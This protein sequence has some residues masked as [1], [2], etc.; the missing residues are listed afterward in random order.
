L[1]IVSYIIA[2][3]LY[4]FGAKAYM[5]NDLQLLYWQVIISTRTYILRCMTVTSRT[6]EYRYRQTVQTTTKWI[7]CVPKKVK[8]VL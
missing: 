5:Y 3:L 2:T 8:D 6:H 4:K 7:E 1:Y